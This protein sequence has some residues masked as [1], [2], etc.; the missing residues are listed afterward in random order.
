MDLNLKNKVAVVTGSSKGIGYS[1]AK[2]FLL[3][4]AIVAICARNEKDLIESYNKLSEY[5]EVYYKAVDATKDLELYEFAD[6]VYKK[7]GSINCWV[8]NVGAVVN[9]K[10]NEF[11]KDEID[12]TVNICFNSVVY[13]CQAAFRYM[14]ESGG[15]IVNISSLAARCGTAGRSTL[16]GPLKSAVVSL[17]VMY[18]AEYSA[19]GV[20]V[21]SVL[22][23]FTMTPK[24]K[25]TI[26]QKEL[27]YN[28]NNTLIRR[29]ANSEDISS[30]VVFLSSDRASYIT[31]ASLEISGGR[32]VVLNP[33][34][35][36][37]NKK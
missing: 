35:S 32:N 37:E 18:A 36:Y 33:S 20:R 1:I 12:A 27:D 3:E 25:E 4:G 23:G 9:R 10:G 30:A 17:S 15:S 19:Y 34:F 5:G 11:S 24:V 16:Y 26:S 31:A 6:D 28:I 29:M 2:D 22:P 21:N 13:G 8:N 14:K 7:Y